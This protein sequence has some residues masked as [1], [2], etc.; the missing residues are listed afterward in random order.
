[1]PVSK[2]LTLHDKQAILYFK[3]HFQIEDMM[4]DLKVF[5]GKQYGF[6]IDQVMTYH[7]YD[8]V[9]KIYHKLIQAGSIQ[10]TYMD[11]LSKLF[12][13]E[14]TH[15]PESIIKILRA[16]IQG[17]VVDD[18]DLG[19]PD[20]TLLPRNITGEQHAVEVKRGTHPAF[21]RG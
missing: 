2:D 19:E 14:K 5:V 15:T 18:L 11:F 16:E 7:T 17:I 9:C 8:F 4:Q 10:T 20:F 21:Q 1:M 13:Y 12:N 6:D 3:C